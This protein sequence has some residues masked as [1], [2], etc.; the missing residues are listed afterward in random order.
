VFIRS[1]HGGHRLIDIDES[2][3]RYTD[4]R[5]R[6]WVRSHVRNQVTSNCRLESFN[7]IAAL[8]S[9]GEFFYTVN[10]GK[11]TSHTFGFF[12]TK[13]CEHLEGE[14]LEWRRRTVLMLDNANYH[15]GKP[16]LEKFK[17]LGA[18]VLFLGPYHFRMAP[19]E[20]AFNFIKGHDLNPLKSALTSW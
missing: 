12:L 10:I 13:L 18:P 2:V 11:T 19:V 20:M 15:R 5:Q 1:L 6:G 7:I 16:V 9:T 3:I 14:D 17:A 8:C 4:H